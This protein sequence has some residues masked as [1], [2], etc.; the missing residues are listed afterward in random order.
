VKKK[1][2]LISF[3]VLLALGMTLNAYAIP[4]TFDADD[5]TPGFQGID[6]L[7]VGGSTFNLLPVLDTTGTINPLFAV[8]TVTNPENQDW[9]MFQ[10]SVVTGGPIT[11]VSAT[12]PDVNSVGVSRLGPGYTPIDGGSS[13][14][15]PTWEFTSGF[16]G[17]RISDRL[18]AAYDL[19]DL[20]GEDGIVTFSFSDNLNNMLSISADIRSTTQPVPEPATMLLLGTGLVGLAG[21]GRKKFFKK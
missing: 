14:T 13:L 11:M 10:V 15:P 2:L 1:L 16:I 18:I 8:G 7:V 6:G 20:P 12:I 17:G 19:G 21:V 3:G 4:Y 5:A 9:F